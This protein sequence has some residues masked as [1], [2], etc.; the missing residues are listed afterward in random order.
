MPKKASRFL[1]V[2]SPA[3]LTWEIKY[4]FVRSTLGNLFSSFPLY[5]EYIQELS[6]PLQRPSEP[7]G[8]F[9]PPSIWLA[10]KAPSFVRQR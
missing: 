5:N 6:P 1:H 3:E 7:H 4:F 10:Q 2:S 8:P 9:S